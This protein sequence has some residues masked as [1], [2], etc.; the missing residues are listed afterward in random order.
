MGPFVL[1]FPM[2]F[3]EEGNTY[4][5]WVIFDI[6]AASCTAGLLYLVTS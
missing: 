2:I 1:F 6:V 5:K 4:R 3:T